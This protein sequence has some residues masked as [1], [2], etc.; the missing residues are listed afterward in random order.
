MQ[1]DDDG[2]VHGDARQATGVPGYMPGRPVTRYEL[3]ALLFQVVK[4]VEGAAAQPKRIARE[5]KPGRKKN[6]TPNPAQA[7][8]YSDVPALH[9]AKSG[10]EGLGAR[11]ITVITGTKF[12]GD[13]EVLGNEIARWI[14][15]VAGWIEGRPSTVRNVDDLVSAGYLPQ[16]HP[17]AQKGTKPL[18]AEGVV[19][20]TV[21][22]IARSQEKITTAAADSRFGK[23]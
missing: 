6:L 15:G 23:N 2:H 21:A 10:I 5:V 13:K 12:E 16:T 19:S 9:W 7:K 18:S 14:D 11:G 20:M 4:S 22:M 1:K 17:A 3:A 8:R